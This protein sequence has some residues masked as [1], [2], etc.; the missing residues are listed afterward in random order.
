[1]QKKLAIFLS[2]LL[3]TTNSAFAAKPIKVQVQGL[4]CAFCA[5][6]IEKSLM[7]NPAVEKVVTDLDSKIVTID[8]KKD[9]KINDEIIKEIVTDAGYN[10]VKIER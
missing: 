6:N 1:M 5:H 2:L 8:L 7:K 9:Q 10:V 4:V 3:I